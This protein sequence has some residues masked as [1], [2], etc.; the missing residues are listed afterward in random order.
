LESKLINSVAEANV[1]A[2]AA[3][4]WDT[5]VIGA[6]VAGSVCA[7]A[8]AQGGG[9]VLLV[10]RSVLPRI[11][12]CG[13]CLGP[14]GV[15]RLEAARLGA[16]LTGALRIEACELRVG[17]HVAT[18]PAPGFRVIGR[19]VLDERLAAAAQAAG[20]CVLTGWS[21]RVQSGGTVELRNATSKSVTIRTRAIIV[22]DGLGG[23]SLADRHEFGWCTSARSRM[24]IGAILD[25]SPFPL[26][27]E[28]MSMACGRA[29]YLGLVRLP[30]G[31]VDAAASFDPAAVRL[32][33]GPAKLC[34]ELVSSAGGDPQAMA[35]ADWRGTP[36]LTRRRTRIESGNVYVVGDA[37][38]YVEPFTG[39][40]MTWAIRGSV[41]AAETVRAAMAG[42]AAEGSWTRLYQRELAAEHRR[43][44]RIAGLLRY[45]RALAAAVA[46]GAFVPSLL[47]R[48]ASALGPK[49][50][51]GYEG[52]A[53]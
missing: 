10:E 11:K 47:T 43:C 28:R 22:A 35:S 42:R 4:P 16:T 12:V 1:T 31:E 30:T 40:G 3:Q 17:R 44:R 13:C 27:I 20:A 53:A 18:L 21:A 15:E 8:L 50:S 36:L 32:A 52:W 48:A 23:T 41:L 29:G 45:P 26:G 46:V 25:R 5:V 7:H 6:G 24:G 14:V 19:D 38:G 9:R 2:A 51:Q 49:T 37:A 33:G 34:A 39:E